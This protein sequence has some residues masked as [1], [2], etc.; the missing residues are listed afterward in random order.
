MEQVHPVEQAV[1]PSKVTVTAESPAIVLFKEPAGHYTIVGGEPVFLLRAQDITADL[2]VDFWVLV[3]G[4]LQE[5]MKLGMTKEEAVERLRQVH[6]I[7]Y[8]YE[9]L[10][11]VEKHQSAV[12]IAKMMRGHQ[13][14][15]VAD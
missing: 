14:R 1:K 5:L 12:R 15:K 11:N 3:N 4:K 10:T 13:D 2:V 8:P 7:P 6:H 9:G